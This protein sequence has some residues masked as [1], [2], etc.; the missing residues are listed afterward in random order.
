MKSITK[1]RIEQRAAL[2]GLKTRFTSQDNKLI[3][4][5]SDGSWEEEFETNKEVWAFLNG[6]IRRGQSG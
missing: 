6:Y 5:V 4:V 1:K 3:W 2:A